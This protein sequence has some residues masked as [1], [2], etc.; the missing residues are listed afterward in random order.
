MAGE[1]QQRAAVEKQRREENEQQRRRTM[2][3]REHQR[4][5]DEMAYRQERDQRT[6]AMAD[7]EQAMRALEHAIRVQ[8]ATFGQERE[9][10]FRLNVD[11]LQTTA[12]DA[13]SARAMRD[14]FMVP[15]E[16]RRAEE[17][18]TV[19]VNGVRVPAS[20][21]E[22]ALA[23]KAQLSGE[24]GGGGEREPLRADLE[25]LCCWVE[26]VWRDGTAPGS[27]PGA[28]RPLIR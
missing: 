20:S 26:P 8:A 21:V 19:N 11:G 6:D 22:E 23:I 3:D 16:P 18:I 10:P 13:A 1:N 25:V 2:E 24:G 15:D 12:P 17:P 5:P 4:R 9:D 14:Q 7:K 27:V 28:L